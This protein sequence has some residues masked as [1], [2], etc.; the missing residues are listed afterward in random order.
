DGTMEGGNS[1]V[2]MKYSI[3]DVP[4]G[5]VMLARECIDHVRSRYDVYRD[6]DAG[7]Y[8]WQPAHGGQMTCKLTF[9]HD[10]FE[11]IKFYGLWLQ[12]GALEFTSM[13]DNVFRGI[14]SAKDF[15]YPNPVVLLDVGDDPPPF[16]PHGRWRRNQF[17]GND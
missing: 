12:G 7:I 13:T 6:S 5:A 9:E 2:E 16:F 4:D 10:T 8:A 17:I 15:G 11:A 14:G 3:G 1:F